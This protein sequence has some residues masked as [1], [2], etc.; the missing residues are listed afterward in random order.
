MRVE[1]PEAF[2]ALL[3]LYAMSDAELLLVPFDL[4]K[5]QCSGKKCCRGTKA[6][7]YGIAPKYFHTRKSI[8]FFD[9]NDWFWMCEKHFKLYKRLLKSFPKDAVCAKL[10]DFDKPKII[11]LCSSKK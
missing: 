4:V 11:D 10:F 9:I 2:A 8:R 1:D 6:R 7:D 5:W 3:E